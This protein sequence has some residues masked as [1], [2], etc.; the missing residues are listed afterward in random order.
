MPTGQQPAE[1]S[2]FTFR[3]FGRSKFKNKRKK[4]KNQVKDL[5]NVKKK[6]YNNKSLFPS[7]EAL[8]TLSDCS[9]QSWLYASGSLAC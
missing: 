6:C 9:D 4:K 7:S 1:F 2:K 8:N 5:T 3:N